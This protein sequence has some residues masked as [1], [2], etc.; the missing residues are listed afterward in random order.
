MVLKS[1]SELFEATL[2]P[3]PGAELLVGMGRLS[4]A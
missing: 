4:M 2:V 3:D 1:A